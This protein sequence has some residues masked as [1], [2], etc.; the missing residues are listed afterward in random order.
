[1]QEWYERQPAGTKQAPEST[2]SLWEKD[3]AKYEFMIKKNPKPSLE[4][5]SL[6]NYTALQT[7]CFTEKNIIAIFIPMFKEAR[8]RLMALMDPR[9][10]IF[11]DKSPEEFCEDLNK[12]KT[13]EFL[14]NLFPIKV[15]ISKYDKSQGPGLLSFEC[16]FYI[17]MGIP[18]FWV[19]LRKNAHTKTTI[20]DK[21]NV[22]KIE[23]EYQRKSGG[24]STFFGNTVV[25]MAVLASVI[26][27]TY[28]MLTLFAGDDSLILS[29]EKPSDQIARKLSTW[30][31]LESKLFVYK[32]FYF[33]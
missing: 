16:M 23:V 31:N 17:M 14:K 2:I 18:P 15:D 13:P 9:Y 8:K 29:R 22:V 20:H 11:C 32:F 3:L 28:V 27:M 19:M 26:D 7:I 1:M 12:E 24:A 33:C 30:Y 5:T 10:K 21:R 6:H 25:L 4:E